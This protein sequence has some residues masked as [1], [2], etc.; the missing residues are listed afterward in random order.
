[1]AEDDSSWLQSLIN[2]GLLGGAGYNL[3]NNYQGGQTA[4]NAANAQANIAGQPFNYQGTSPGFAAGQVAG[5]RALEDYYAQMGLGT[6]GAMGKAEYDYASQGVNNDYWKQLQAYQQQQQTA[7]GGQQNK[8]ADYQKMLQGSNQ[9][10][11]LGALGTGQNAS[12]YEAMLKQ[13]FGM[14]GTGASSAYAMNQQQVP[15]AVLQGQ[16]NM[17]QNAMGTEASAGTSLMP[18]A[19]S[20]YS[21]VPSFSSNTDYGLGGD[22]SGGSYDF[23][24]F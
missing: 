8:F 11:A 14:G 1:M 5:N 16:D 3:Y 2:A 18:Q 10:S 13:I 20:F 19:Q 22:F 24:S 15:G 23:G 4:Q 12:Q 7:I 17:L 21:D 9:N 6:S